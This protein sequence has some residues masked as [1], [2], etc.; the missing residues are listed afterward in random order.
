MHE[1]DHSTVAVMFCQC[2]TTIG[3]AM[4]GAPQML[5]AASLKPGQV[6]NDATPA[7]VTGLFNCTLVGCAEFGLG[8]HGQVVPCDYRTYC[9]HAQFSI[10]G[11]A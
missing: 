9:T 2:C 4:E 7:L 1:E 10:F 6:V 8:A 3:M 11:R 5:R